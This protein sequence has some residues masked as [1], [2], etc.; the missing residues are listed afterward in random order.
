MKS[1]PGSSAGLVRKNPVT[2][3]SNYEKPSGPVDSESPQWRA[4]TSPE[5]LDKPPQ[6]Q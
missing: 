4:T 1:M 2:T 3:E 5:V 6:A